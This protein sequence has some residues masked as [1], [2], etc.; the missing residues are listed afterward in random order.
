MNIITEVTQTATESKVTTR[1]T[2]KID[3]WTDGQREMLL[4]LKST[5]MDWDQIGTELKRKP[6][7][8]K[9]MHTYAQMKHEIA[10]LHQ[11]NKNWS[12]YSNKVEA[13]LYKLRTALQVANA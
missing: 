8:C 13:K 12:T 3:K 2:N 5:G 7:A 10:Q 9:S 4:Y 11:A 1:L 6:S